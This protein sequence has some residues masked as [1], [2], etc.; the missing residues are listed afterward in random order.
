MKP[1]ICLLLLAISVNAA[2]VPIAKRDGPREHELVGT[3]YYASAGFAA[4]MELSSGGYYRCHWDGCWYWGT[5]KRK[6]DVITIAET[7]TGDAGS[8]SPYY[9][10]VVC[11]WGKIELTGLPSIS[12]LGRPLP[13]FTSSIISFDWIP[14]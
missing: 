3:Y 2:P 11:Y 12:F 9:V 5:W 6:G 14:S 7:R 8:F 10:H 1:I 13:R 4:T